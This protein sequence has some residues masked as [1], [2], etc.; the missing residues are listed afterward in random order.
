MPKAA[1]SSS[2]SPTKVCTIPFRSS[3]LS[4]STPA[5]RPAQDIAIPDFS[6]ANDQAHQIKEALLKYQKNIVVPEGTPSI[7]F[8]SADVEMLDN[9]VRADEVMQA[10]PPPY[11][12]K[13]ERPLRLLS[14][15]ECIHG[16]T[17]RLSLMPHRADGGGVRGVSEL[18][19]LKKVMDAMPKVP[20]TPA[21]GD[22][23][24][25]TERAPHPYEVFDM[26]AGTSTGGYV[27][28]YIAVFRQMLMIPT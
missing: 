23:D 13:E 8:E 7:E 24:Q 12:E 14:L 3:R 1:T 9:E 17:L 20:R 4:H 22:K 6:E 16:C 21:P 15:G 11:S 5:G 27:I 25:S 2:A 26:I 19:I 18:C 10:A 28:A